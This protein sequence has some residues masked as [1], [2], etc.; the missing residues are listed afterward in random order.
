[1][2]RCPKCGKEYPD[3]DSFCIECGGEL[4]AAAMPKPAKPKPIIRTEIPKELKEN[5][6]QLQEALRGVEAE[7]ERLGS[8]ITVLKAAKPPED[9]ELLKAAAEGNAKR[10]SSIRSRLKGISSGLKEKGRHIEGIENILGNFAKK[11][12]IEELKKGISIKFGQRTRAQ[13]ERLEELETGI[14]S[15]LNRL[16][17]ETAKGIE[18]RLGSATSKVARLEKELERLIGGLEKSMAKK[19]EDFKTG[20]NQNVNKAVLE[21]RE[22]VAQKTGIVNKLKENLTQQIKLN[23]GRYADFESRMKEEMEGIDNLKEG[24]TLQQQERMKEFQTLLLE[25][26]G[27]IKDSSENIGAGVENRLREGLSAQAQAN[28]REIKRLKESVGGIKGGI[29]G[30]IEVN[31]QE[32]KRLGGNILRLSNLI[33]E[34]KITKQIKKLERLEEDLILHQQNRMM[35]LEDRVGKGLESL[36]Q[37]SQASVPGLEERVSR[38]MKLNAMEIRGLKKRMERIP[39]LEAGIDKRLGEMKGFVK[40]G[41]LAGLVRREEIQDIGGRLAGLNDLKGSVGKALSEMGKLKEDLVLQQES[42]LLA[43][44]SGMNSM[45]AGLRQEAEK[46]VKRAAGRAAG[47]IEKK[48][49]EIRRLKLRLDRLSAAEKRIANSVAGLKGFRDEVRGVK[50]LGQGLEGS[51]ES[52]KMA[53]RGLEKGLATL[54]AGLGELRG[55]IAE[56]PG[57]GLEKRFDVLEASGQEARQ[58]LSLMKEFME[59]L[60]NRTNT[61]T[62]SLAKRLDEISK[63]QE[64]QELEILTPRTENINRVIKTQIKN[65]VRDLESRI[66]MGRRILKKKR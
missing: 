43:M 39:A 31:S 62:D 50:V 57:K 54:E 55:R 12:D 19:M 38:G 26:L 9:F 34:G 30:K 25:R 17:A 60:E 13:N 29:S 23:E 3:S 20:F 58:Q 66:G 5:I 27:E 10:V 46:A 1:M 7:L 41:E 14:R 61:E 4:K 2:K 22:D 36:R 37:E 11:Q 45:I 48:L 65:E 32:I 15:E 16:S 35:V 42:K 64:K 56:G 53:V 40:R 33:N 49:K 63:I 6:L 52:N 28:A 24:L 21:L 59:N 44:E 51:I 8:E 18:T 47:G